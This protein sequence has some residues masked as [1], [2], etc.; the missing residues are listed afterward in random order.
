MEGKFMLKLMSIFLLIT[1]FSFAENPETTLTHNNLQELKVLTSPVMIHT[2]GTENPQVQ[3]RV[4]LQFSYASSA[5]RRFQVQI[6]RLNNI[7]LVKV[8]DPSDIDTAGE[9]ISRHYNLTVSSNYNSRN[10]KF[11][12]LNPVQPTIRVA[13]VRPQENPSRE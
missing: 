5:E 12:L 10:D 4:N 6:Q 8:I 3:P 1:S 13:P 7:Q 11:I 9:R 2:P